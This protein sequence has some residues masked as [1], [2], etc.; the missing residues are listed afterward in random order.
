MADSVGRALAALST[1]AAFAAVGYSLWKRPHENIVAS[2]P[3]RFDLSR[4]AD[5]ALRYLQ[6]HGYCVIKGALSPDEI[7][8][9]KELLWEFLGSVEPP[10]RRDDPST[11]VNFPGSAD[12]GVISGFGVGQSRFMWYLRGL[13][14]V[15]RAYEVAWNTKDLLSSFDGCGV[16]RPPSVNRSWRTTGGWHHVDQGPAKHGFHC[17]QGFVTLY[18]VTEETGGLIVKP[19]THLLH[20]AYID[21]VGRGMGDFV[22]LS[23]KL[24]ALAGTPPLTLIKCRAGDMILWDSR[25]VHCNTPGLREHQQPAGAPDLIR[26]V[27]YISMAPRARV[28]EETLVQRRRA[29]EALDTSTHWVTDYIASYTNA[30]QR[31]PHPWALKLTPEQRALI[32]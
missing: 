12:N 28:N 29:V 15:K 9:A 27:A 23:M 26:V 10:M 32:G 7:D 16:F 3:P 14:G 31:P 13:P 11:W 4:E 17:V 21:E 18:D 6:Q 20:D 25:T 8:H 5:D 30:R 19:D 1:A 22:P 24:P 2:E